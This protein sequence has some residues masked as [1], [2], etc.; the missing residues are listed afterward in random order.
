MANAKENVVQQPQNVNVIK[1]THTTDTVASLANAKEN[2]VKQPQNANVIKPTRTR[3]TVA[4]M[5]NAKKNVVQ[6][7]Q[8]VNVIK[9]THEV[10]PDPPKFIE[11][12]SLYRKIKKV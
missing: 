1:P 8:N 11:K 3:N 6:Q 7:P 9:P 10:D 12:V 2:V 4:R 5:V